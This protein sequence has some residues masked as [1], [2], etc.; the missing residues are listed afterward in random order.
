MPINNLLVIIS[1]SYFTHQSR[2]PH[3]KHPVITQNQVEKPWN[4]QNPLIPMKNPNHD[5]RFS[6]HTHCKTQRASSSCPN[7]K[8]IWKTTRKMFYWKQ[9]ESEESHFPSELNISTLKVRKMK[10]KN[11]FF[12]ETRSFLQGIK[13]IGIELKNC[14]WNGICIIFERGFFVVDFLGFWII[15]ASFFFRKSFNF[16]NNSLSLFSFWIRY[17]FQ[18]LCR[19]V[20]SV[21]SSS[22]TVMCWIRSFAPS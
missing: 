3:L 7:E 2:K 21:E 19:S 16:L 20:Y 6:L 1:S 12:V 8:Q 13:L 9:R 15:F 14:W 22:W 10:L 17:K 18:F 5:S 4:P 11:F